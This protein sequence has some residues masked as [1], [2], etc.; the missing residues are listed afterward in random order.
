MILNNGGLSLLVVAYVEVLLEWWW[1]WWWIVFVVWLT[2]E[3]RSLISSRDHCQRSSP[4]RISDMPRAGFEPVQNLS[5]GFDEWSCA[6]VITTTPP[7]QIQKISLA[8]TFINLAKAPIFLNQRQSWKESKPK[9]FLLNH[10]LSLQ[11]N[12]HCTGLIPISGGRIYHWLGRRKCHCN[13]NRVMN[14]VSIAGLDI[15]YRILQILQIECRAIFTMFASR[16]R[17]SSC[18]RSKW[19]RY[20]SGKKAKTKSSIKM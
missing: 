1:W 5:S 11:L 14:G 9:T 4:S 8:F 13:L 7:V 12:N 10:F 18:L 20:F 15:R 16:L 3:R 2:D 17:F 6:V 19:Y